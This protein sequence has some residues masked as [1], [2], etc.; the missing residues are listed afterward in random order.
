MGLPGGAGKHRS[1]ACNWGSG[2]E[3]P[4]KLSGVWQPVMGSE[5]RSEKGRTEKGSRNKDCRRTIEEGRKALKSVKRKS[6]NL[7]VLLTLS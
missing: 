6:S 3:R 2:A 1:F 7:F 4:C 5:R